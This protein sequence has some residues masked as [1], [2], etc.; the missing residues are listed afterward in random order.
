MTTATERDPAI[1]PDGSTTSL[2]GKVDDARREV[3]V[4]VESVRAAAGDAAERMPELVRT[5]RTG[6]ADAG[7]TIGALPEP[8]QRL[9]AV[10]SLGLGIGLMVAGAPRVLVGG[11]L[12]PALGVAASRLGLDTAT[13]RRTA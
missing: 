11:A 12:L 6:A 9:L 10:F 13:R 4:K 1:D 3:G 7:R 8:T 2:Q 5:V